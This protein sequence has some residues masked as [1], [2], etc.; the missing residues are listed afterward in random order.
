[1]NRTE[2]AL[3]HLITDPD[4]A[5]VDMRPYQRVDAQP[6]GNLLLTVLA[7]DR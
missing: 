5:V 3:A 1:M 6:D 4:P 2:Y 7:V